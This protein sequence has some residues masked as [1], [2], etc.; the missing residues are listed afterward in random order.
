MYNW[1]AVC[2]KVQLELCLSENQKSPAENSQKSYWSKSKE[3]VI[4]CY[5][6]TSEGPQYK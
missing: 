4:K 3:I 6:G 5:F 2:I 1:S